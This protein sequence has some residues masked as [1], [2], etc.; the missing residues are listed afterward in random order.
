[1]I[2]TSFVLLDALPL[3]ANGKLDMTALPVPAR[4]TQTEE[5]VVAR[6][7]K[8]RILT[9]I[10]EQVLNNQS[11]S[12]MDNFF[13]LGGDSILSI[14]IMSRAKTAGLQ[15]TAKQ[16]FEYQTVAELAAV[17]IEVSD[18]LC[19]DQGTVIG[20]TQLSPIQ[21][22]YFDQYDGLQ[23]AVHHYNQSV[24]LTIAETVSREVIEQA[25]NVILNQHDGLRATFRFCPEND[26]LKDNEDE[27]SAIEMCF[28]DWS[29]DGFDEVF[30]IRDLSALSMAE[31][32]V[33]L[34]SAC[35]EAQKSL[36]VDAG[37]LLRFVYF[38]SPAGNKNRILLVV[39]HLVM[40]V[41][42]WRILLEDIQTVLQQLTADTRENTLVDLGI[43]TSSWLQWMDALEGYCHRSS[44]LNDAEYWRFDHAQT[45]VLPFDHDAENLVSQV[46]TVDSCLSVDET[47]S[48]L[49]EAGKAYRTEINDL[50]LTALGKTVGEWSG[51][52]ELLVDLEGHGREEISDTV[53]ISRTIGWF[54]SIFPVLIN[55]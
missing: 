4:E 2:P 8:E 35:N 27:N 46:V 24:L 41:F 7:E 22:F 15:L 17:A 45:S 1:M 52:T 20:K 43:K 33:A 21:H 55:V 30:V 29:E 13:E 50:L 37:P 23:G 26:K 18:I 53:D 40:D 12:V 38:E 3:T 42:S 9:A 32:D 14:Q 19:A 48:L 25:I 34:L 47:K 6:N 51:A 44:V 36:V 28:D 49:T 10:W 39:H 5:F 54:T 11:I 31:F 16:I